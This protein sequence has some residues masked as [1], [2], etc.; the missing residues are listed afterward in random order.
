MTG[1]GFQASKKSTWRQPPALPSGTQLEANSLVGMGKG[2]KKPP[3]HTAR[4]A[5]GHATNA[6]QAE[7]TVS[8]TETNRNT[9]TVPVSDI[10]RKCC[11]LEVRELESTKCSKCT[12]GSQ[13][14]PWLLVGFRHLFMEAKRGKR[15][16]K[17]N[18]G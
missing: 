5:G 2:G 4:A 1:K 18:T 17:A 3:T 6:A 16:G 13:K 9:E 14:S 7:D 12:E 10:Y 8:V 15:G 11:W